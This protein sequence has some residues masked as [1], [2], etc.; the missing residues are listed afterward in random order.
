MCA[1]EK[2]FKCT[3]DGC[4]RRFANSSDRK[5]HS[6]VHCTNKPWICSYKGCDKTYTHPSSLRKHVKNHEAESKAAADMKEAA[7]DTRSDCDVTSERSAGRTV[8]PSPAITPDSDSGIVMAQ[9]HNNNK[10]VPNEYVKCENSS[11]PD[12]VSSSGSER[13]T[14]VTRSSVEPMS[15]NDI[16]TVNQT[17]AMSSFPNL[18][19][20]DRMMISDWI[21]SQKTANYASSFHT[22]HMMSSGYYNHSDAMP[23]YHHGL[24]QGQHG[25]ALYPGV[26]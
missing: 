20:S 21:A 13:N 11:S 2:P 5:K 1:G 23:T 10:L 22:P 15:N 18:P 7:V 17:P 26:M 9:T 3:F 19:Q 4:E 12:I 16:T 6:F 8:T 24:S 25:H 14:D